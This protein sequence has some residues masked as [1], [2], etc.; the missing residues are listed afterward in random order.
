MVNTTGLNMADVL[1][2]LY[3]RSKPQGMGMLHYDPTPMK[4]DEAENLLAQS[5]YF[6]YLKGRVMKI[7]LKPEGFD[8]RAYDR[9]NGA[10]SAEAAISELRTSGADS[11]QIRKA[12]QD[13]LRTEFAKTRSAIEQPTMKPHLNPV[14]DKIESAAN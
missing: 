7:T 12:H 2:A 11:S 6:D 1:C 8:E 5:D 10:G 14:L 9:D 3:N 4:C 13:G